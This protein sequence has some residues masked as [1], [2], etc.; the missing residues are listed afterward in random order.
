MTTTRPRV[1]LI[2]LVLTLAGT[3]TAQP[4]P[5]PAPAQPAPPAA[6]PPP[7]AQPAPAAAQPPPAPGTP[8]PVAPPPLAPTPLAPPP[9]EPLPPDANYQY[10]PPPPPGPPERDSNEGRFMIG[11]TWNVGVPIG[12]VHDFTSKVSGLGFE[13]LFKYWVHPNITVGGG[14]DWQTYVD[15]RPRTTTQIEN[16][17]ITATAYNSTQLGALRV[18]GDYYFLKEGMV[19]PYVGA[20]IGIGWA[21]FQS[22]AADIALYDNQESVILGAELGAAFAFSKQAPLLLVGARYSAQPSSEF[23]TVTDVQTITFQLGLAAH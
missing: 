3:A 12:S 18:G 17:A 23:L 1:S 10:P 15:S 11:M 9:A 19:L 20:N 2:A 22:S 13:L 7:A 6:A 8:P 5:A 4:A 14:V 16:G 21:T